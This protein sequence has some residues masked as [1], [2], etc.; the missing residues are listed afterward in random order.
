VTPAVAASHLRVFYGRPQK[1][2]DD[3]VWE[4]PCGGLFVATEQPLAAGDRVLM[5]IHIQGAPNGVYLDATVRWSRRSAGA[6][7]GRP[8]GMAVEFGE[9]NLKRVTFLRR[10]ARGEVTEALTRR[11]RRT[12]LEVPAT[13]SGGSSSYKGVL[14]D[15]SHG[16]AFIAADRLPLGD[17]FALEFVSP[18]TGQRM[19]LR[20]DVRWR[21][22]SPRG[23]GVAFAFDS[24]ANRVAL[25]AFVS[26]VEC[27]VTPVTVLG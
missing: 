6:A 26:R 15:I 24:P 9:D 8:A 25:S 13:L 17:A 1:F 21:S 4:G 22:S 16:G 5:E 20:A 10:M 14:R 3:T 11:K 23:V 27:E 19:A 18:Y 2:I 7:K 12:P